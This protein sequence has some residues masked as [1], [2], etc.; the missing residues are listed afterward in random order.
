MI[1]FKEFLAENKIADT[2][3]QH[4]ATKDYNVTSIS[5]G[6][7]ANFVHVNNLPT[8]KKAG[9]PRVSKEEFDKAQKHLDKLGT[10][11]LLHTTPPIESKTGGR[12]N[13]GGNED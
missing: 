7:H 6:A 13:D 12:F 9:N 5:K 3:K 2:I 11:H 1:R 4:M 8:I 10:G